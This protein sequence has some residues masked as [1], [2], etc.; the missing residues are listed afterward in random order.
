METDCAGL[1]V[2]LGT[3]SI[4][5][6]VLCATVSVSIGSYFAGRFS[7]PHCSV[8]IGVLVIRRVLMALHWF[9]CNTQKRSTGL[10][11]WL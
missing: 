8:G 9:T 11:I 3:A 6:G 7:I 10:L 4:T 1:Q 2:V 5:M